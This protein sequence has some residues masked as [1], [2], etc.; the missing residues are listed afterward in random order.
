LLPTADEEVL[1][2][3]GLRLEF[4]GVFLIVS[5]VVAGFAITFFKG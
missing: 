2:A 4:V 5:F 3:R 1:A